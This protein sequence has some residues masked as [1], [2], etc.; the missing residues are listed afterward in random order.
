MPLYFSSASANRNYHGLL[1][2]DEMKFFLCCFF[3]HL[4]DFANADTDTD[5]YG[6][7]LSHL[8]LKYSNDTISFIL[9]IKIR[10]EVRQ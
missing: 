2:Q 5:A 4:V 1:F 7:D 6:T 8:C 9:K 10:Q 3:S